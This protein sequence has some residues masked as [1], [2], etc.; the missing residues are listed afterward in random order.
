MKVDGKAIASEVIEAARVRAVALPR[1]PS[2]VAF[3]VAPSPA[4][5]SYLRMKRKQAEAA[6]V[7]MDVR[8]LPES[9]TTDDLIAEIER[10]PEDAVIVQ[11]PLPESIDTDAVLRAIPPEKDADVLSPRSRE[12]SVVIHPIAAA[13]ADILRRGGVEVAGKRAGVVGQG[14]L[15]GKPVAEWLAK[16]GADVFVVTKESGRL[17]ELRSADIIVSGAGSAGIITSTYIASGASVIDVGT[18]ELGG[19]I[20]GDVAP[21][22]EAVA[23][24]FTPVP[25]GVGPVAV[26][27][28]IHN[29]VALSE[30][31]LTNPTPGVH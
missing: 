20:A 8:M 27:Y 26:A 3:V 6:G 23:G 15:V 9:I 1:P 4:T 24:L 25:G 29:V 22:V 28:L 30:R 18:S 21:E 16:E 2:F 13:V 10:A 11:L 31:L 17:E 5:E 14:W 7:A 12:A 19:A